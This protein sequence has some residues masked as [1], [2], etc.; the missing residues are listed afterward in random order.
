[1]YKF[2]YFCVYLA[3]NLILKLKFFF[4]ILFSVYFYNVLNITLLIFN[5]LKPFL[6]SLV[7]IF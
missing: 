6:M 3:N 1:M 4:K 7:K 2:L 5:I